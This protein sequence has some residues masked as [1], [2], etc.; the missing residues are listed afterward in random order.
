MFKSIKSYNKT[1]GRVVSGN[2]VIWSR[3]K[4]SRETFTVSVM[5][6]GVSEFEFELSP[7][8]YQKLN[9]AVYVE[10][11]GDRFDRHEY[12][13]QY[14]TRY[15]IAVMISPEITHHIVGQRSSGRVEFNV[16]YKASGGLN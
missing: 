13:L 14:L 12:S 3:V 4:L 10:V 6:T 15:N 9:E 11:E 7:D 16:Y 8:L 1:I 5:F 2:S